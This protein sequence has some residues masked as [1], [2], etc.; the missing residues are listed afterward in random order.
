MPYAL[1]LMPLISGGAKLSHPLLVLQY[2]FSAY[3]LG[4]L[5][6][7]LQE[8]RHRDRLPHLIYEA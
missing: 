3:G 8:V 2:V 5:G 4:D 7:R 1:C 6:E